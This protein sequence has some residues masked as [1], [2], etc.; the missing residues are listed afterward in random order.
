[1]I[2]SFESLFFLL[3]VIDFSVVVPFP[4]LLLFLCQGYNLNLLTP[5]M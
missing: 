4:P 3:E 1:M 5:D 2:P